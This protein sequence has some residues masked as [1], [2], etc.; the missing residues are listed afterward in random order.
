M[1]ASARMVVLNNGL[2]LLMSRAQSDYSFVSHWCLKIFE[3]VERTYSDCMRCLGFFKS[4]NNP[5]DGP[6]IIWMNGLVYPPVEEEILSPEADLCFSADPV[7][8]QLKVSLPNL[9]LVFFPTTVFILI[10]TRTVGLTTLLFYF[11]INQPGPACL[12]WLPE[13]HS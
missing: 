3:F 4:N 6:V 5:I 10:S 1:R 2:G 8:H 11:S 9:G 13:H 12:P 7:A